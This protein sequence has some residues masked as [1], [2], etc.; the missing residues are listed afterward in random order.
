[1]IDDAKGKKMVKNIIEIFQNYKTLNCFWYVLRK[2]SQE[3]TKIIREVT[4][5][6]T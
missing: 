4:Q 1:M 2:N 3:N 6:Y 5:E